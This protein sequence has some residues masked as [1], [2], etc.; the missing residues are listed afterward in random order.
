MYRMTI[1]QQDEKFVSEIDDEDELR[2]AVASAVDDIEQKQ[3]KTFSVSWLS[4]N[5]HTKPFWD[6]V[7]A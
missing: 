2:D 6:E 5:T 3:I 1:Y 4:A 7:A